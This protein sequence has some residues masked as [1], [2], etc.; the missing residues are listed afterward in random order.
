VLDAVQRSRRDLLRYGAMGLVAAVLPADHAKRASQ[1]DAAIVS[2]AVHPAIGIARVGNSP[3]EYFIGPEI[4]GRHPEPDGGFKDAA[5]RIKRQAARFRIY[6]LDANGNVVRELTAQDA[7]ISW[8]VHLANKKG[9]WY[10]FEFPFDIPDATGAP[11]SPSQPAGTPLQTPRRNAAIRGD[12]RAQLVIDPGSRSIRGTSSNPAGS[13]SRYAFDSGSFL[14]HPVNLGELRTDDSGRLLMLGGL[15][16]SGLGLAVLSSNT[17]ANNDLWQDDTSDGPVDA[18]V[19]LGDQVMQATGAWV[20]VAPPNFAPGIEGVITMYDVMFEV[21]TK[22]EPGRAPLRPSFTRQIYPLLARHVSN[23][24]VNAGMARQFGWQSPGYFIADSALAQLSDASDANRMTRDA[25]FR[26]FRDPAFTSSDFSALPP[27]YGDN[28]TFPAVSPRQWAAVLPIQYKWLGQWAAGDFDADWPA[29]GLQFPASLDD[30]PVAE[31]PAAL[32]RA[33]LDDCLGGA[34]HPGCE[35]TWPV[36]QPS[37]YEAPFR[38]QRRTSPE[39][40]WGPMM[41]S[42]I[43]LGNPGPLTASASGDI[44]RWMAVPWQTD[45]ASCLSAYEPQVDEYLPTFW[46]AHVPNDVLTMGAYQTIMNASATSDAKKTAFATRLKWL[47]GQP[48]GRGEQG[49]VRINAFVANWGQFGII[50]RKDGPA[51]DPNFPS[52]IWV[53]TGRDPALDISNSSGSQTP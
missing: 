30:F 1:A 25:L 43:A 5:G 28:T 33:A 44:T 47:R 2:C 39:P 10:N 35:M 16:K 18:T 19:R 48:L 7:D 34:F 53:E 24:W 46:P 52:D 14:S 49:L 38:F 50:T 37:M 8:T 17:F 40:D 31:Q 23:Q 42:V 29:G 13:D 36:R 45:T 27:Y 22:L 11:P 4:P 9:A 26:R 12:D 21:A 3:G 51:S 32:D 41:T 15:G 20:V 6:G